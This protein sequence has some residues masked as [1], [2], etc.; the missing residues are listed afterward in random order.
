[1]TSKRKLVAT[2][3]CRNQGSRLYGK[4]IQNL[5]VEQKIKVI[6]QIIDCIKSITVIDD[7]VLAVAMGAENDVFVRI[8]EDHQINFVRG[9]EHD[10]LHRL[11]LAGLAADATDIFRVTTESP[12]LY[13]EAVEDSWKR[14]VDGQYDALFLDNIVDGCGFEIITMDALIKSHKFGEARHRSEMCSLFIR[15]NSHEFEILRLNPPD[16]LMRFDLRLT[17][18]NPEDLVVCRSV[19]NWFSGLHPRIPVLSII[20]FLDRNPELIA[21]TS[22]FTENGYKTMYR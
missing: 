1:M 18:D 19:F 2:L 9:D 8:A 14:F 10:V 20:E 5:D 6:D 17:I 7:C 4:P 21:L 16:S 12:F 15:E 22:P 11:I 3:A 13:F